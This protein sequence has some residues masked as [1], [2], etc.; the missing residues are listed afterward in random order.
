MDSALVEPDWLDLN[1]IHVHAAKSKG[2]KVAV[3]TDAHYVNAFQ[4]LRFGVDHARRGWVT[5]DDVIHMRSLAEF[6]ELLKR[7][8]PRLRS[9]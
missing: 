5:A 8:P 9:R 4:Y 7:R 6:R 1:D 2:V 3:S